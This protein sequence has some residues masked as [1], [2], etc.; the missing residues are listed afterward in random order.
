LGN[1]TEY[2]ANSFLQINRIVMEKISNIFLFI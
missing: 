2:V 1:F